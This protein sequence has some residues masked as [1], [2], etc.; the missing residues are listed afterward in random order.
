[1]ATAVGRRV[2]ATVL[3]LDWAMG[4]LTWCEH[5]QPALGS[6]DHPTYRGLVW[7]RLWNLAEEQL[8]LGRS[9]A[10]NGVAR[11]GQVS[12]PPTTRR[13]AL[14]RTLSSCP[15]R[16]RP[17]ASPRRIEQR[18]RAIPE[19]HELHPRARL[20][21]SWRVGNPRMS[22]PLARA[23]IPMLSGPVDADVAGSH[24][25]SRRVPAP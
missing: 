9:V 15:D 25:L 4:T 12:E 22:N 24:P 23:T 5:M 6:V 19:W 14:E 17:D 1:M 13:N 8:R 7:S 11:A 18:D 16:S 20:P 3:D 21:A 10:L 2:N